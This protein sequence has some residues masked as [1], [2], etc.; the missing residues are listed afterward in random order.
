MSFNMQYNFFYIY[1]YIYTHALC[2]NCEKLCYVVLYKLFG[3]R[4]T[5]FRMI[6]FELG[7]LVSTR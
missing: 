3:T 6:L 1:I 7:V 4:P 2:I 5:S